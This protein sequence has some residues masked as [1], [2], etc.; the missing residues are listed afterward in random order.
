V[1]VAYFLGLPVEL[2]RFSDEVGDRIMIQRRVTLTSIRGI[3]EGR[4]LSTA[5]PRH[6]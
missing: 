6:H 2:R 3:A 1:I 4:R 5:G